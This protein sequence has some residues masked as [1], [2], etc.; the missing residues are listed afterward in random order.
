MPS[1]ME[2]HDAVAL[3]PFTVDNTPLVWGRIFHLTVSEMGPFFVQQ[4]R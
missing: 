3:F 2:V 4:A 1:W